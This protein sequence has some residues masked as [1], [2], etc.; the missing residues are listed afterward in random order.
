MSKV[1]T[2]LVLG[3][4]SKKT[5]TQLINLSRL[6]LL[7]HVLRATSTRL[8]QY[9]ILRP[10]HGVDDLKTWNEEKYSGLG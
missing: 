10:S 4:G 1:F 9:P 7:G 5:L 8:P 2:N 3:A 6:R